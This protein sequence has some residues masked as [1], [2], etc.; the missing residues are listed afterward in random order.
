MSV[1][2]LFTDVEDGTR[3]W[4]RAE[5]AM[6]RAMSRHDELLH[7]V[8]QRHGGRTF[9]TVGDAFCCAFERPHDALRA[10]VEAQRALLAEPWP[11]GVGELRVRMGLHAGAAVLRRGEY[12][13]PGVNRA[14]SLSSSAV[15][16]QILVSSITAS[17]LGDLGDVQLRDLG[18]RRFKD[19][20]EPEVVFE[21]VGPGLRTEAAVTPLIEV[22]PNNLP[23]QSSSFIGRS[24][25]IKRLR[26][27]T[28][29]YPLVTI[30]GMGGI[31]KTRLALHVAAKL[32]KNYKDGCWFVPLKDVEDAGL[33][34]QVAADALRIAAVPGE[35]IETTLFEGLFKKKTLLVIDNAEH[36]LYEVANFTRRLLKSAPGIR[37]IVTSREPLHIAGEHVLRLDGIEE[38][39]QLFTDRARA[40]GSEL[41]L[42]DATVATICAKLQGI[43]LAIELAAARTATL[44]SAQLDDLLAIAGRPIDATID[45]SYR[46]LTTDERRFFRTLAI[47]EGSFSSDAAQKI[48]T[49]AAGGNDGLALLASL[50]DKSLVFQTTGAEGT[51]YGLLEAVRDFASERLRESGE[52]PDVTE[53][54]CAYYTRFVLSVSL[55]KDKADTGVTLIANEWSNVRNALHT[56]LEE[57]ADV[58]GGRWAV[59]GLWEFWRAT[60]RTT[61][62]WYW[63]NRA[64]QGTDVAPA[65]RAELLQRAAQIAT[66]RNDFRSL[67]PLARLL[68]E[69]HEHTSDAAA[70]GNALQLL[71]NAKL[72]LGNG[73]EAET[74]QRR[75]LE[76]FRQADDRLGIAA[77][78]ANLGN[79]EIQLHM[80][81]ESGSRLLAH[82]LQAFRELG[83]PLNCAY[84]L[85]NMSVAYTRMG[86]LDKAIAFAQ[87]SLTLLKRFGNDAAASNQ[88][89]NI[90]E[91]YVE[92]GKARE[93]FEALSNARRAFGERPNPVFLASYFEAAFKLAVA[94]GQHESGAR[95]YG[96]AARHRSIV[97]APLLPIE[98]NAMETWRRSLS[99]SLGTLA[100]D[101]LTAEGAAMEA[102]AIEG[103]I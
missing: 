6:R 93:A 27:L 82:S 91:I 68:I 12:C 59:R 97:R 24:E 19:L 87:Q 62:G 64:L 11:K 2:F 103:L 30:A 57:R 72:G 38:G 10:A 60:G 37:V 92:S 98:Q 21:I 7:K 85:A 78:L 41:S 33:I 34:A 5:G 46:L 89:V 9:K 54:H 48:G 47:F 4:E 44:S 26:D 49:D 32:L 31:G 102:T 3:L 52:L 23:T 76:Q 35:P 86:E 29:L 81:Y 15:G 99:A 94:M 18:T 75:A 17:M 13:G 50:V 77:A 83:Q 42:S 69:I 28:T 51:R 22:T 20:D 25:E 88:Y 84:A 67:D 96:Y 63:V 39:E 101:R 74:Y 66:L 53:R 80:N 14:A 45:W 16:G 65:L 95:L 100:L 43:P 90:A 61:E 70:L 8:A 71:A 73:D 55:S 58:D 79:F 36:L 56:S 1:T 40:L